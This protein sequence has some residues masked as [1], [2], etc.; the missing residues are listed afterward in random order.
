MGGTA[1]VPEEDLSELLK[2]THFEKEDLNRWYKKFMK[3]YP[4]GQ[5]NREQ[6]REMY[7]KIYKTSFSNHMAEHIF[8]C[9]DQNKDGFICF[10]ELMA[11]LSVTLKGTKREK[12]EWSFKVYDL[13][14]NGLISL[15]EVCHMTTCIK[16]A[17]KK[18]EENVGN[19]SVEVAVTGSE[20]E[21]MFREVDLDSNGYW[22]LEEFVNGM[23]NHPAFVSMLK[24]V[25]ASIK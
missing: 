20:V 10:K 8:R 4:D 18:R 5:L 15:D 22:S 17:C 13:D 7:A 23:Q 3:D 16:G 24:T 1:S 9:L 14:G 2:S 11:G 6:F 25:P 21:D 12:L 19:E